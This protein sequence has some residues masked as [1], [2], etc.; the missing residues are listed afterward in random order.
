MPA[1]MKKVLI[2]AYDFPPYVSVGALRPHYWYEHFF[3]MGLYPVVITRNWNPKHG[4]PLDYI[5]PSETKDTITITNER[6]TIIKAPYR[7]TLSNRLTL[8]GKSGFIWSVLK[9]LSTGFYEIGQHFFPI[10]TKF[11]LYKAAD[12]YLRNNEVDIIIATGEPF[13][14][15][16]YASRLSRKYQ[17]PWIADYRDTWVKDKNVSGI[18]YLFDK[19]EQK[20]YLKNA[21][22]ITT[23]SEFCKVKIQQQLNNDKIHIITNGYDESAFNNLGTFKQNN[24]I[25]T[26]SMAGTIYDWHPYLS[27]IRTIHSYLTKNPSKKLRIE[28]YGI[29]K[30]PEI[31]QLLL[32][33]PLLKQTVFYFTKMPNRQLLERFSHSNALLLF[34]YYSYMGTKIYECLA[35]NRKILLCFENDPEANKLKNDYY[36]AKSISGVSEHLQA[37]LIR[38]TNSGIVVENAA[39]LEQVLNELFSEFEKTRQIESSTTNAEKYS[40]K[41]QT[42]Q[43]AFLIKNYD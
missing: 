17:L 13:I 39:H 6:G 34:N 41:I 10:G 20:K 29:N 23:V 5:E 25:L 14:L 12:E 24:E 18:K 36:D 22:F 8:K 30:Q 42:K 1:K 4:S 11:S 32:Q 33:Y 3:E 43:L 15:F 28:F 37:D 9:K 31:E 16:R 19:R 27:F 2:L 35:L 26:I 38:E 7:A 21:A 40:R